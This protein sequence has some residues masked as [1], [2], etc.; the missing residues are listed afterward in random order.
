MPVCPACG[1]ENAESG[2]ACARCGLA[3]EL[4][5][6][7]RLAVGLP[8]SDPQFVQRV[9]EI[10]D[11]LGAGPGE[12][13]S[14]GSPALLAHPARFPAIPPRSAVGSASLPGSPRPIQEMPALPAAHGIAVVRRQVEEY[15]AIARRQGIDMTEFADRARDAVAANEESTFEVLGR[16][17]FIQLAGSFTEEFESLVARRNDLA[18][19]APTSGPDVE[20]E[21]CRAALALGDLGGA[22]RRLRHLE[23]TLSR[24]ED[25]WATVQVLVTQAELLAETIRELGGDPAPALGPLA[26]GRRLAKSGDR[27][28]AEPVLA[29]AGLALW[30]ILEPTFLAD[31]AKLKDRVLAMRESGADVGPALM[32]LREIAPDLRRRSFVSVIGSYRRLRELLGPSAPTAPADAGPKL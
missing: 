27:E 20:F 6:P 31:L 2:R 28:P 24:L 25:D 3:V 11:A 21:S 18:S 29:R 5:E 16:S 1:S 13:Q 17:L 26:E 19:F 30:S 10:V 12:T 32:E 9:Q 22:Q 7:V 14:L 4:F 8:E 15:L 23:D